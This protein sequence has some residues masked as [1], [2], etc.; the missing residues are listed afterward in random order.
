MSTLRLGS[1]EQFSALRERLI[2]AGYTEGAVC[3]TLGVDGLHECSSFEAQRD[4]AER[5]RAAA[6]STLKVL[7]QLLV[8]GK[9]LPRAEA[10]R[11]IPR[12]ALDAMT[13]L[14]VLSAHPARSK[15]LMPAVAVYPLRGLYVASERWNW[16]P[17]KAQSKNYVFSAVNPLSH[18]FLSL[19]PQDPCDRFLELCS[20]TAIAALVAARSYAH[21]AWAV[22]IASR[23]TRFGDFNRRLNAV[24]NA[25]VLQGDLYQ[26]VKGMKFDRIV[27]HTPWVPSLK[28]RPIYAD[29]GPDGE[30]ITRA[31]IRGLPH[32]LAP[33]GRFYCLAANVEREG[34]PYEQRARQ[35]L[36]ARKSDFDIVYVHAQ[37]KGPL[38]FAYHTTRAAKGT[39]Q[40]MEKWVEHFRKLRIKNL[41]YGLLIVQSRDS[42][43]SGF[44]VR[45]Q[46]AENGAIAEA[47][48]LRAWE[49]AWADPARR[50]QMMASRL[51]ASN[52]TKLRVLHSRKNGR[53]SPST[54]ILTS[55]HPFAVEYECPAWVVRLVECCDG[56]STALKHFEAGKR[57]GWIP[58]EITAEGFAGV[59]RELIS[60]G[61][62]VVDGFE[63]PR[64]TTG[65]RG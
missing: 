19:L 21:H 27:A 40:D 31:I 44:T 56:T 33:G 54:F 20:G 43:G 47:E 4:C 41:V 10:E 29:G 2:R 11:A 63:P 46:K 35:W 48:W 49:S 36:G 62:L 39:W 23:A 1:P 60:H 65:K 64:A 53:L 6:P 42:H 3:R 26:P 15:H 37:T 14:G 52:G 50:E 30:R 7:V 38:Q 28:R 55:D 8:T 17:R 32:H 34:E 13:A 45:R 24:E 61:I 16:G 51:K 57:E 12:V 9:A 18:E 25:T 5:V 59:F 58:A 22:D